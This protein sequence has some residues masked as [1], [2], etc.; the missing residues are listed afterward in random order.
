MT[1]DQNDFI[2][3]LSSII[4]DDVEE[5]QTVILITVDRLEAGRQFVR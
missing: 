4:I 2:A 1:M 5:L 3:S